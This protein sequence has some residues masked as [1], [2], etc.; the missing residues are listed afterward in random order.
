MSLSH[1]NTVEYNDASEQKIKVTL[2]DG[3]LYYQIRD[4]STGDYDRLKVIQDNDIKII[5]DMFG[6]N[7]DDSNISV[8][9]GL[10][11]ANAPW[12]LYKKPIKQE[13]YNVFKSDEAT[14]VVSEIKPDTSSSGVNGVNVIV[15]VSYASDDNNAATKAAALWAKVRNST[16]VTTMFSSMT[17]PF[18]TCSPLSG[19]SPAILEKNVPG[20]IISVA[21][22][23]SGSDMTVTITTSGNYDHFAVKV[24]DDDDNAY[25]RVKTNT[26]VATY[27]GINISGATTLFV[28]L[29]DKD[30]QPLYEYK[31]VS[32]TITVTSTKNNY[33]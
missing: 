16:T 9:F 15:T 4:D 24:N 6:G 3:K 19:F 32:G 7:G 17:D 29:F 11:F 28:T 21:K 22:A 25:V 10:T 27:T 20:S 30:Y 1:I 5:K 2:H 23:D 33:Y 31:D 18:K 8:S 14:C 26:K 12:N 13:I